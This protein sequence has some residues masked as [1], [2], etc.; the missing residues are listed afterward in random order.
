MKRRHCIVCLG[1]LIILALSGILAGCAHRAAAPVAAPVA[2]P[3]IAANNA[4]TPPAGVVPY[5]YAPS[6]RPVDDKD[7]LWRRYVARG[8]AFENCPPLA[9]AP[10]L[11]PA[12][13]KSSSSSYVRSGKRTRGKT[14]PG[15]S[16]K[17]VAKTTPAPESLFPPQ[18][19]CP[20]GCVPAS[21]VNPAVVVPL[22]QPALVPVSPVPVPPAPPGHKATTSLLGPPDSSA[23]APTVPGAPAS[24]SAMEP[25]SSAQSGPPLPPTSVETGAFSAPAVVPVP[26]AAGTLGM[27]T[28][29]PPASTP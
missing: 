19:E 9:S 27:P 3:G 21:R 17:T 11:T 15:K 2:S 20:P 10:V 14:A 24:P 28:P 1:L 6:R 4:A 12:P 23:P 8:Q 7:P 16:P 25:S 29:A 18:Q 5:G 22:T 13:V 26:L